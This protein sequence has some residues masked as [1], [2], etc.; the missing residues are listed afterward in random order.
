MRRA[1]IGLELL[2]RYSDSF[3]TSQS[4]ASGLG[5]PAKLSKSVPVPV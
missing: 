2:A 3:V 1:A 4:G 5:V